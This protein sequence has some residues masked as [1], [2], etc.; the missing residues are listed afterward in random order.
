M[1]QFIPVNS[2]LLFIAIFISQFGF[3]QANE[4]IA[5]EA[6]L[7]SDRMFQE[8]ANDL[9]L[10]SQHTSKQSGLTHYYFNQ[11]FEGIKIY[12][13][14]TNVALK[15]DG[16]VFLKNESLKRFRSA[17]NK[18]PELQAANALQKVAQHFK[19]DMALSPT[20]TV[21]RNATSVVFEN[22]SISEREINTN[23]FYLEKGGHLH[24]CW[25]VAL[26]KADDYHW[27]D[28]L[29]SAQDG[30]VMEEISWTVECSFE[31]DESF[32][33]TAD[34]THDHVNHSH[35]DHHTSHHHTTSP[36]S[37][38]DGD[39]NVIAIP[40]ESPNHGGLAV[41][42]SPWNNNIDPAAHPFDWHQ[43]NNNTFYYTRGNNVWA[44][45]DRNGNNGQNEGISASSQLGNNGQQYNYAPNF[46]SQPE[47][48]VDAAISNL[49]YVNNVVHDVMYHY[50]FD[51]SSGN[52]Q[53]VNPSGTGGNGSDNVIANAQDG[54]G[55]NNATFGTPGDGSNPR[56]TM[57]EWT[58][59]NP[60][61]DS[62]YDNGVIIHEYGHGIS[63]RLTGGRF[64]SS[65]L[66]NT[67]QM[68][69]G[70]SDY[71]AIIM[72]IEPGD[73]GAGRRGMATYLTGQS[74]NGRGIRQFPYSTSF[75]N[76]PMT[77]NNSRN[78][79]VPHGVGSVWCTALWEMT[80]ALI[81][82]YGVGT[83]IYD[84]DFGNVGTPNN[85]G[86]FG[87]QNMA[88][89]LV[90]EGLKLQP[91]NPGFINGR[92]AILAADRALY[93]GAHQCVL[94]EAFA[95]RGLGFSASQGSTNS[96]SDNTEAFDLPPS[97][98]CEVS[99]ETNISFVMPT[100]GQVFQQCFDLQVEV[101]IT[102]IDG[103]Q[104]ASLF[105]NDN[106]V[107]T[108]NFTP[109]EWGLS[110]GDGLVNLD[111]GTYDLRVEVTDN[112]GNVT[113]DIIQIT[114]D[115]F[116]DSDN[117]GICNRDD[118]C[119]D[120]SINAADVV[121]HASTQDQGDFEISDGGNGIIVTNNGWKAI[122]FEY[123]ITPNTLLTFQFKADE[124]G[125]E[126][127]IGMDEDLV[128]TSAYRFKLFGVQNAS[129]IITDFDNYDGSGE[130]VNYTIPIGQYYTGDM[131]YMFFIMDSDA[132]P[133]LGESHFR[134]VL[135][136]EDLNGDGTNDEC[137]TC[138]IG[139]PC[140]DGD[141]CTINDTFT[142][143]CDCVGTL[144]DTDNDG[145]CDADDPCPLS[146]SGDSDGDG[147]CD[148]EDQCPDFDDNMDD[149]QNGIPDFCDCLPVVATEGEG[150][151][152]GPQNTLDNDL[153]TRWSAFG[154]GQAIQYCLESATELSCL[155]I[156]FF[157]GDERLQT[158]D[159]ELLDENDVWVLVLDKIQSSGTTLE[160]QQFDFDPITASKIRITGFG[161]TQNDW[162]SLT[163]VT[164][165]DCCQLTGDSCDDGDACTI[166]DTY[167][168]DCTCVG[169]FQ[170]SDDDGICDAED[171]MCSNIQADDFELDSGNWNIGGSDASRE[172]NNLFQNGGNYSMKIQDNSFEASSIYTNP[173]DLS[174]SNTSFNAHF[175]YHP[176]GMEAGES[177]VFEYSLDA[178]NSYNIL[179]EWVSGT[180]FDN[181][182][183]YSES[184][185]IPPVARTSATIFRFR[186]NGSINSDE[187]Y[188]DNIVIEACEIDCA[189]DIV[190]DQNEIEIESKQAING[191]ES[192]NIIPAGANI[193]YNAGQFVLLSAGFEVQQQSTFSVFISECQ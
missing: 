165:G 108:E 93:G 72:T 79:A 3:S 29:I 141:V 123:D 161:N 11:T 172:M 138:I 180:H 102:D 188:L 74:T 88:L 37:F 7:A 81:D 176:V 134:N 55:T 182:Q 156:A 115:G 70:W 159:V 68:G 1:H 35:V 10:L 101:A 181:D 173:T 23:L 30:S 92:D 76:N 190:A 185:L 171:D 54:S 125:E 126:H 69:E 193:S 32:D 152:I 105:I 100:D 13:A 6:L 41:V 85:P 131:E 64:N 14:V 160:L 144:Q 8:P 40:N 168:A 66:F 20:Q 157:R 48:Y 59:T 111:E 124:E 15:E 71:F 127:S 142:D 24:L 57:F 46:G 60:R 33:D 178:G 135:L 169:E 129:E 5:K 155:D 22:A 187:V 34:C 137:V 110:P 184:V 116:L 36:S 106:F 63:T 27:W 91:C 2:Y 174:M 58:R 122:P 95:R 39:Y 139:A 67:E 167:D 143:I 53:E 183:T 121:S 177:F 112:A 78:A 84:S 154:F 56:M 175:D 179:Q 166:N 186:C 109:Y 120:V 119:N 146:A 90:I 51:E 140:D 163:E 99:D 148:D 107:R 96:N 132:D 170:D 191:I 77:Y 45:E 47:T 49:F 162:T 164:W 19:L 133:S 97:G 31:L 38:A 114:V 189:T 104:S 145:V 26:E 83:N 28:I 98:T 150:A 89:Q 118:T 9:D 25:S 18:N 87:G 62:D 73:T 136:L 80:W 44:V 130:F 12:N 17:D 61:R 151:E 16:K 43:F 153:S 52:F 192:N 4:T 158:F 42:N 147:V 117:D 82:V 65:C 75:N 50:G 128:N 86:T 113:T 149:N 103:V 94:W 21:N